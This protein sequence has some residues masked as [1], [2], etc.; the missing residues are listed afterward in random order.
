MPSP[1]PCASR[2]VTELGDGP[3]C[4]HE[5]VEAPAPP[6]PLV[7]QH[8]RVLRG[9]GVVR[10]ERRGREI[11]YSLTD[12]HIGHI[13]AD[14]ITHARE[15]NDPLIRATVRA[16]R[17]ARQALNGEALCGPARLRLRQFVTDVFV[18]AWVYDLG[19]DGDQAVR[20]RAQAGG[21]RAEARERRQRHR[22]QP[23]ATPA[24]RSTACRRV[25]GA[26]RHPARTGRPARPGH[27]PTRAGQQQEI[28]S[29][30]AIMLSV[31]LIV[32]A[33]AGRVRLAAVADPVDPPG[34]LGTAL[35]GAT[36]G[37]GPA[38]AA[39]AGQPAAAQAG[40]DPPRSRQPPGARATRSAVE[41]LATLEL[42]SLGLA[43]RR[44][45][46]PRPNPAGPT[47]RSAGLNYG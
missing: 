21:A 20:P 36:G 34:R 40:R 29:N 43:L 28:V 24:T 4:V 32:I 10:G 23:Q 19:L 33:V 31:A 17:P 45:G 47:P 30:L 27:S 44:L 12:E 6:Q 18:V 37:P 9:A 39:G 16:Q 35:R 22:R 8:L 14:A 11:A 7:S 3:R 25:G 15:N 2:I 26:G 1:R 46:D 13:V 42:R 5:L 38:G 41:R